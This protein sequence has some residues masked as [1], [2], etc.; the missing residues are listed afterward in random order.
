MWRAGGGG[1]IPG[2][3][4]RILTSALTALVV[5][6]EAA[7]EFPPDVVLQDSLGLTPEDHV[8]VVAVLHLHGEEATDPDS[9]LVRPGDWVDFRTRDAHPRV[10]RFPADSLSGD[11]LEFLRARGILESPPMVRP[12]VHWVLPTDSA[13][14]GRYPYR[15]DGSGASGWGVVVVVPDR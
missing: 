7:P 12:G 2:P 8:H 3:I 15:V 14:P 1:L 5:A 9:I 4:L 10:V 13:P 6:C 11:R